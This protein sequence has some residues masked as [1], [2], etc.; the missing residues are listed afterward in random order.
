MRE[1]LLRWMTPDSFG[2]GGSAAYNVHSLYLDGPD[3]SIYRE[4]AAGAFSRYK[5]RA[6][7]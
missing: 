2:E 5:L 6:R 7:C 3:W 4:T 1:W